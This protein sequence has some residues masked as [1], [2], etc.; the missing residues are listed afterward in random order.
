MVHDA[1]LCRDQNDPSPC[2][3]QFES[4]HDAFLY[5]RRV[6]KGLKTERHEAWL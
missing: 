6:L 4:L 5:C 2:V 1:D 3:N